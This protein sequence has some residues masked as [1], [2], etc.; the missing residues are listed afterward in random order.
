MIFLILLFIAIFLY[1][2]DYKVSALLLFF[3]F[4]TNGFNLIWMEYFAFM[5]FGKG[6]DYAL[7]FLYT[8]L[9]IDIL[10]VK[11]YLK[12]DNLIKFWALFGIFLILSVLRSKWMIG[13]PWIEIIKSC[14]PY[15]FLPLYL[16]LKNLHINQLEN[17]LKGLF[18]ATLF[19]SVLYLLQ[20]VLDVFLLYGTVKSKF[21]IVG[22]TL[23][24]YYNQ[25]SMLHFFALLAIFY[26]PYKGPVKILSIVILTTAL[27]GAFHRSLIISFI[28]AL[29]ISYVLTLS[30]LRQIQ[31]VTIAGFLF[32]FASIYVGYKIMQSRTYTDIQ[33]VLSGDIAEIALSGDFEMNNESTFTYRMAHLFERNLYLTEQPATMIWGTGL[34]SEFAPQAKNLDFKIGLMHEVTGEIAQVESPDISYSGLI[35]LLGY[36]GTGL[37]LLLYLYL[38]VFFY[39]KRKM[40]YGLSSMAYLI[41][42]FGTSFFSDNLLQP[43]TLI[44][45]FMA[46]TLI[47]KSNEGKHQSI[48]H[49]ALV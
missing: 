18:I 31:I 7:V 24:R 22:L 26:N 19:T 2:W 36:A 25:P 6:E 29:L 44:M 27:I 9:A 1:L 11:N 16:V 48:D 28:A 23:T 43:V 10:C 40:K 32:V 41:L 34:F 20:S 17:I 4:L 8:V 37:L 35:L 47:N 14:R 15:L 3:F 33:V 5:F 30:K 13:V 45:P 49:N 46:Y 21:Y 12:I 39:K 38:F 42:V